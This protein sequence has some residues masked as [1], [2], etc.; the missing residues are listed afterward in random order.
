MFS[1]KSKED[2]LNLF[3]ETNYSIKKYAKNNIIAI[4]GDTCTSIGLVLEGNVDIKRMLGS[5]VIHLSS[6]S[7]GNVFGEVIAFSDINIYPAT[8]IASSTCEIMFINKNDFIKFC[9]HNEEFLG[10]FLNTLTNKIFLLNNSITN[11]TFTNIRQK[12]CNFLINEYKVQKSKNIKL[13]MT[14]EKLAESLGST[15][16]SLSRE[17]INMK[18]LGLIDYNRSHILILDL[19]EI[20]NLLVD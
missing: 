13:N 19:E 16:P 7:K 4:E 3:N 10:M 5:K 20:K 2:I 1:K 17:L 11:L 8:V 6:F 9:T 12:I 14:K 15:R 18:E